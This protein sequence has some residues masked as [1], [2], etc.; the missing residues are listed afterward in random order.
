[1]LLQLPLPGALRAAERR[2]LERIAPDKD[3]DGFHPVNVGRLWVDDE[4]GFASATPTGIIELL[5]RSGVPL[6]GS[7]A[8]IVGRSN[9][10][11]KP[12][13][14]LL[15]REHATVTVCHSRTRDLARETREADLLIAA[16]GRPGLIGA[17][18]VRAGAVVVDVGMN[19]LD[20]VSELDRLFPPGSPGREERLAQVESRGYTLVGDVDF[21]AVSGKAAAITPVPGGVGLLT[22]A[23]LLVNTLKAARLRQGL[24]A[25]GPVAA[26][27]G[28]AAR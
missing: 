7:R 24:P 14:A 13:A 10:V 6:A 2:M 11:G 22:V 5:R 17:E 23:A 26:L 8:V 15:L 28:G 27:T 9:I 1:V 12:M 4:R 3:V 20:E 18:H 16:I 21:H 19:R 25:A